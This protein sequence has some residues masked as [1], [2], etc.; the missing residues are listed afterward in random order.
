VP[1]GAGATDIGAVLEIADAILLSGSR[2]NVAPEH[3]G[4]EV[5]IK[6]DSLDPLRDA[7]TLPLI[8]AAV[9]RKTPL[10]A[11]CR[12][13][14]ELN[15]ALGG[16][17]HQAVHDVNG[18]KDHRARQDVSLDEAY[19]PVHPVSLRG[20]LRD[21]VGRDEIMVNS[22]HWQGIA[23]LADGLKPE[24]F[25]EDGLIEAVRGP[26]EAAF[27]LGVQWHPEWS[28]KSNEVSTSLFRRFGAAAKGRAS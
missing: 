24:A 9:E 2:S 3:Y 26:D 7:L 18:H 12:G 22:L 17:L 8:R 1:L 20:K 16:S 10:F 27:C 28:A 15:V 11:I 14:Q 25:A 6:P 13:F 5:P 4:K 19:G 23:R 21:W